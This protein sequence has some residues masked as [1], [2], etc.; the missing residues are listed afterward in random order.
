MNAVDY[1]MQ[2][3]NTLQCTTKIKLLLYLSHCVYMC[4]GPQDILPQKLI[5]ERVHYEV[6]FLTVQT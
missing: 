6:I 1:S 4:V 3:A 5:L 2:R